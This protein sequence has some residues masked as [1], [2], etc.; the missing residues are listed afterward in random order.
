MNKE[1]M[2]IRCKKNKAIITFTEG[3]LSYAHG[4][5]EEICQGCYN[6]IMKESNWY[7]EGYQA[8]LNSLQNKS[9]KLCFEEG[10]TQEQDRI[11]ELIDRKIFGYES[12]EGTHDFIS[13]GILKVLKDL[14]SQIGE[15]E[16]KENE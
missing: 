13:E 4:F 1:E 15:S 9:R 7:K 16:V 2:C 8:G 3:A 10:K 12:E 14:K 5:K 6:K 11:L